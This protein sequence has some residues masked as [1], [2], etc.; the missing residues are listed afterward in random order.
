MCSRVTDLLAISL[1]LL[2]ASP[3]TAPFATYDLVDHHSGLIS[4]QAEIL[5]AKV[6]ADDDLAY[7]RRPHR[8]RR[9]LE[10]ANSLAHPAALNPPLPSCFRPVIGRFGRVAACVI[11][12][13]ASTE[14]PR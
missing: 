5:A 8:R 7:R 11:A 1:V 10:A 13:A 3:F 2:A 6:A 9:D 14:M 12:R 4:P